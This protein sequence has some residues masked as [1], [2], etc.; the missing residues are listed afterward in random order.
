MAARRVAVGDL[1]PRVRLGLLHAQ[2]DFLLLLVDVEDHDLDL[3]V[4]VHQL[5]RMVDALG[6][7]HLADVH[8]AFDAV[9]ELHERAVAHDVDDRALDARADR[10]LA[11]RRS[12]TGWRVFCLR[13]RA[14]FSFSWS[15]C[16]IMHLD[17]LVDLH[18]LA[19][20]G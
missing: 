1:V 7:G 20:D 6:P 11:R 4:D 13:P 10:V 3:V 8:Q 12:P 19:T 5:A 16:R 14:I 2:R 17:L 15:M 18:H 9:F